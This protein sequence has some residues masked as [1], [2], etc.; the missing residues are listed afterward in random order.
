MEFQSPGIVLGLREEH[1]DIFQKNPGGRL[2]IPVGCEEFWS[3]GVP[4]LMAE[5]YCN[6]RT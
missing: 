4:P 1:P 6:M 5:G 2:L 3:Y